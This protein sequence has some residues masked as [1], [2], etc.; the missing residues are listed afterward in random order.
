MLANAGET[1][2]CDRRC[3]LVT[4]FKI[5]KLNQP[6]AQITEMADVY[7]KAYRKYPE[8]ADTLGKGVFGY[9]KSF[10]EESSPEVLVAESEGE[11]LGFI[12]V[13]RCWQIRNKEPLGEVHEFVIDYE[14]R[15]RRL[16]S[17][18]LTAGIDFVENH[19]TGKI[20]LWVGNHNKPALSLY[21][22]YGFKKLF[23]EKKWTKMERHGIKKNQGPNRRILTKRMYNESEIPNSRAAL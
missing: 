8:Y 10:W 7:R 16:G 5:H 23:S 19:G 21:K 2:E 1:G 13:D 9:L 12:I 18:L 14:H 17:T 20:G 3:S 22:K 4:D 11:M 6:G 15:G